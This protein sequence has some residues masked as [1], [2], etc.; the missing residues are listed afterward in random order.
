MP[1][2]F[3]HRFGIEAD[4]RRLWIALHQEQMDSILSGE[5]R[6]VEGLPLRVGAILEYA[7]WYFNDSGPGLLRVE[8]GTDADRAATLWE[9]R[10]HD[11]YIGRLCSVTLL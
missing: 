5:R 1:E 9:G 10:I 11:A 8:V 7:W 3:F 4:A 6:V 2:H